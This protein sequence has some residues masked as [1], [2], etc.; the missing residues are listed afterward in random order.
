VVQCV[1]LQQHINEFCWHAAA[2]SGKSADPILHHE[3][4]FLEHGSDTMGDLKIKEGLAY[5]LI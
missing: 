2:V 3:P 5:T 4:R 1:L